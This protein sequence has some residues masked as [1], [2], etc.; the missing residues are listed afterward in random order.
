MEPAGNFEHLGFIYK[1]ENVTYQAENFSDSHILCF[2][3]RPLGVKVHAPTIRK[4]LHQGTC[5]FSLGAH[6]A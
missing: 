5:I 2:K 3:K 4:I 6:V 1:A